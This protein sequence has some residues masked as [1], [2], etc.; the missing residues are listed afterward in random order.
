MDQQAGGVTG[1]AASAAT[2]AASKAG[3][4]AGAKTDYS[5]TYSLDDD[6]EEEGKESGASAA[7]SG[8]VRPG[9]ASTAVALSNGT[10]AAAPAAAGGNWTRFVV[11]GQ[12]PPVSKELAAAV[13][14]RHTAAGNGAVIV[15]WANF[16]LW[17]FVRT[18]VFHAKDVGK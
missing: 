1:T 12:C 5:G 16:A 2:A 10:A 14:R 4:K 3:G 8:I 15:T 7:A 6:E 18:W 9:E 13:A 17:D 11:D